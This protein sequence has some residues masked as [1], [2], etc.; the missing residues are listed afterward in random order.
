MHL[1]LITA[2]CLALNLI[3]FPPYFT[4]SSMNHKG[5][6]VYSETK[7]EPLPLQFRAEH[8]SK[9]PHCTRADNDAVT[10][11]PAKSCV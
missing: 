1:T 8:E 3:L 5:S 9:T 7:K 2:L 6:H 10:A 4:V 11:L